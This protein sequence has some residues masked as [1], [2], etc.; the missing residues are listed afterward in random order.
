VA[1]SG[2][3][4]RFMPT[5]F[6]DIR[7]LSHLI[8]AHTCLFTSSPQFGLEFPFPKLT[9]WT[10]HIWP[11]KSKQ[12][13]VK[14]NVRLFLL[15][16]QINSIM[17]SGWLAPLMMAHKLTG[18]KLKFCTL[19]V[20]R[21]SVFINTTNPLGGL[22]AE[23]QL[24]KSV[25]LFFFPKSKMG[26]NFFLDLHHH[27]TQMVILMYNTWCHTCLWGELEPCET[28]LFS[29]LVKDWSS[30]YRIRDHLRLI[31]SVCT[32]GLWSVAVLKGK[33]YIGWYDT[34]T[35]VT[36]AI[37]GYREGLRDDGSPDDVY[38]C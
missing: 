7:D 33:R 4:L 2:P 5:N 6:W 19:Y 21:P 34:N 30:L 36:L 15:W 11:P 31:H 3:I 35:I 24:K 28:S 1:I 37:I 23:K 14:V 22:Y 9:W 8:P 32:L 20:M 38:G 29:L 17:M 27:V 16:F 10:V 18:I 26:D 13:P 12:W 25:F